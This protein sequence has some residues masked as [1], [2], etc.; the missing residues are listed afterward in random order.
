MNCLYIFHYLTYSLV[1]HSSEAQIFIE[2]K[3]LWKNIVLTDDKDAF[4]QY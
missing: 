4:E 3:F 1:S 2:I